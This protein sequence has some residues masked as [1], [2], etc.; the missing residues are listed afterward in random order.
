M[1]EEVTFEFSG[2]KVG[3]FQAHRP[4]GSVIVV[5]AGE[6]RTTSDPEEVRILDLATNFVRRKPKAEGK[7]KES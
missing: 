2:G 7:E 3:Q 6:P 5:K 4:D 1:A